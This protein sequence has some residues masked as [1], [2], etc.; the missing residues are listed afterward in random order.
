MTDEMPPNREIRRAI[1]LVER[2]LDSVL[3]E[4]NLASVECCTHGV[5]RKGFRDGDEPN[6]G[7]V[8]SDPAG[9]P[10]NACADIGQPGREVVGQGR[11]A[12]RRFARLKGSRYFFNCA[13]RALACVAFGPF[14]A[15]FK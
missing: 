10:R 15:S 11:A 13:T 8:A 9:R 2:F 3:A 12:S 14:G 7:G 1:H 5:R 6:G 4:V